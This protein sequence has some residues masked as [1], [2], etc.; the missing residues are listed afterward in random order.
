MAGRLEDYII[1]SVRKGYSENQIKQTL[2]KQGWNLADI[3]Q[4]MNAVMGPNT[5]SPKP[6]EPYG[7]QKQQASQ[8]TQKKKMVLRRVGVLSVAKMSAI[9]SGIMGLI[10]GIVYT[11]IFSFILS[12]FAGIPSA[13]GNASGLGGLEVL[14]LFAG[15]GMLSIVII[16]VVLAILGFLT[17]AAGAFIYNLIAGWVG[18][19]EVEFE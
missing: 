17:G 14:G 8:T 13:T 7:A 19:Y 4:A 10:I 12:L 1:D 18:G 2:L 16:P 6:I 11:L 9:L 15:F 5:P 3:Y